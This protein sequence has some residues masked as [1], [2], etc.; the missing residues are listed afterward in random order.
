MGKPFPKDADLSG[1]LRKKNSET[2]HLLKE[3][4]A[5]QPKTEVLASVAAP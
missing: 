1:Q 3:I 5:R 2:A 4:L